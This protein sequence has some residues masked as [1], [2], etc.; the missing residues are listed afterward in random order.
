MLVELPDAVEVKHV[1]SRGHERKHIGLIQFD[2]SSMSDVCK[3][4]RE[5]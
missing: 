1:L 3:T 2:A 5:H 4:G